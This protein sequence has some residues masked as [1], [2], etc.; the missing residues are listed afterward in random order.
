MRTIFLAF[1]LSILAGVTSGHSQ[2]YPSHPITII[3][4]LAAGT[5]TVK[6]SFRSKLYERGRALTLGS[7]GLLVIAAAGSLAA[8]RRRRA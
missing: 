1:V 4:P 7:L 6:L 3:V 8:G 5:K 2:T